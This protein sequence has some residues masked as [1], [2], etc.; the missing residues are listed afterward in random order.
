M[1]IFDN[2]P[3][4]IYLNCNIKSSILNQIFC[5]NKRIAFGTPLEKLIHTAAEWRSVIQNASGSE[6]LSTLLT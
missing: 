6:K 3:R 5:A 4:I 1:G 2:I